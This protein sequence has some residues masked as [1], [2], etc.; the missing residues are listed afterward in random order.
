MRRMLPKSWRSLLM[1]PAGVQAEMNGDASGSV[2]AALQRGRIGVAH[3]L[4][5]PVRVLTADTP[6]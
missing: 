1:N 5:A 3:L 6:Q 2:V 4:K